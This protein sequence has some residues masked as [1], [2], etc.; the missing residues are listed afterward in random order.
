MPWQVLNGTDLIADGKI[1]ATSVAT[2]VK[3]EGSQDDKTP[4]SPWP[5]SPVQT[6]DADAFYRDVARSGINYGQCF[7][8]VQKASTDGSQA[9][10]R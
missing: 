3:E 10:M 6:V 4:D 1:K 8:M 7:R 9:L 5:H 2:N